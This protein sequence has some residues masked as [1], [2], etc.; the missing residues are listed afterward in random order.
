MSILTNSDLNPPT[1]V[2]DYRRKRR[3]GYLFKLFFV[4]FIM[5]VYLF[6]NFLP[7]TPDRY[8]DVEQHYKYGSI[9]SDNVERGL[10]FWVWYVLPEMFPEYLPDS[11]RKG[12]ESF[13]FIREESSDRYVGFSK[14]RVS[15]IDLIGLNCAVCHASTWARIA[16]FTC[17]S[18]PRHAFTHR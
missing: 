9:G 5:G 8:I 13:G 6:W 14:R 16:K 3:Y 2:E 11:N 1:P 12:Y 18:C 4:F 7:E 17:Q 15:G 10:P